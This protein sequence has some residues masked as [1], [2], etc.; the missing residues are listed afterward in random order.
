MCS[1]IKGPFFTSVASFI[2]ASEAFPFEG[3]VTTHMTIVPVSHQTWS[4]VFS[5]SQML[6]PA[7]TVA[8]DSGKFTGN[9]QQTP[10]WNHTYRKITPEEFSTH[11]GRQKHA[12]AMWQS[13]HLKYPRNDPCHKF[14]FCNFVSVSPFPLSFL[15]KNFLPSPRDFI[16]GDLD[17]S[18]M[19]SSSHD[20]NWTFGNVPLSTLNQRGNLL[21]CS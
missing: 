9:L 6:V 5:D 17:T 3:C 21:V 4:V 7:S 2:L 18:I 19:P 10:H 13:E 12:S 15:W 14:S 20:T 8:T 1:V 11:H 16:L